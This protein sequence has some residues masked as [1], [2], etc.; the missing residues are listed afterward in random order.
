[1][2]LRDT[3]ILVVLLAGLAGCGSLAGTHGDTAGVW[4]SSFGARGAS[5]ANSE[6]GAAIALLQGQEFGEVLEASDRKAAVEAQRRALRSRGVGA[7][8]AWNNE[9][10]GRNGE[11]R[12]GPVYQVNKL[13]CREFTH[14]MMVD[15][16][17]LTARGTACKTENGGWKTLI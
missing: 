2:R 9:K 8:I 5:V 4:G 6:A 14:E 12:P 13:T 10:T 17:V 1:M 11:V 15:Q 7:A 16:K 3:T